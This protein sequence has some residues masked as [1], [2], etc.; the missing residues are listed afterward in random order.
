M[1]KGVST[2]GGCWVRPHER[3]RRKDR[4]AFFGAFITPSAF[5]TPEAGTGQHVEYLKKL[6]STLN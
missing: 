2:R 5:A 4:V 6:A 1:K 3:L